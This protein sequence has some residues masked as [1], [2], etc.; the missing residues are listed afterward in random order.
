[1]KGAEKR[2]ETIGKLEAWGDIYALYLDRVTRN[3]GYDMSMMIGGAI[4]CLRAN[5]TLL[6]EL[7]EQFLYIM[8]DEFQDTNNSQ[9]E[10][11]HTLTQSV[12]ADG[13]P[14]VL[15]VGDD[16]QSV[17]K[18]QGANTKNIQQFVA[19]YPSTQCV[20]LETNYRSHPDIVA[21]AKDI[22]ADTPQAIVL[23]DGT[24][25]QKVIRS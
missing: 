8:V 7:Q 12:V 1:L 14:N 24:R 16:D 20:L 23:G 4:G 19:W 15:V 25:L 21:V 22:L 18:F 2:Y 6:A 13:A 11:V 17:Y 3:D 5:P 10:L 9:M